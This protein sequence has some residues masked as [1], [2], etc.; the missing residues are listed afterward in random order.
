MRISR[1]LMRPLVA[2]VV[3]AGAV[4]LV[5]NVAAYR[6]AATEHSSSHTVERVEPDTC[7]QVATPASPDG[8]ADEVAAACENRSS[9]TATRTERRD[10]DAR[11]AGDGD[12]DGDGDSGGSADGDRPNRNS[13]HIVIVTESGAS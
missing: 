8:D 1:D 4:V 9:A 13:G 12:D 6:T 2:L 11:G 7:S 3:V 10:D 5:G